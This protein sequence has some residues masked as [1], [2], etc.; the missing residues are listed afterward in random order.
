VELPD[1]IRNRVIDSR[2]VAAFAAL[3]RHRSFTLAAEELY[4]TQSAVSHAIKSLERDMGCRLFERSGRSISLTRAGQEFHVR[5]ENILS[6]M[7]AARV[8]IEKLSP[9]NPSQLCVG[10]G[11]LACQYV[12]P[13][14]LKEFRLS[15]ST[16]HVRLEPGNLPE[17]LELLH[18][19]QIDFALGVDTARSEEF[20]FEQIFEDELQF[21]VAA[22]HPW[23]KLKRVPRAA[24]TG[25]IFVVPMKNGQT[26]MLLE[27]YFR[28]EK[29]APKNL[30]AVGSLDAAKQLVGSGFG[31]GFF[32][33]WQ[34]AKEATEG[35][36]VAV[37][38]SAK[39]LVRNWIVA[40]LKGREA[41]QIEREFIE[42]CKSVLGSLGA[43]V[44]FIWLLPV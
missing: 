2:Q 42:R 34:V 11:T 27:K 12:L 40:R 26:F 7:R 39:R 32:A 16:C 22:Q 44:S 37:A 28:S 24:L 4:L 38:L 14:V 17:L 29:L 41:M 8:E 3:V 23:G 6:E 36:L 25:E 9:N 5:T 18:T 33:P 21:F 31:V 15:H 30:I 35:S 20:C 10:A 13:R 19:N 1:R 43:V